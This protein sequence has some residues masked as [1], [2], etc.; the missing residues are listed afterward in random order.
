MG[1][2]DKQVHELAETIEASDCDLVVSATPIDLSRLIKPRK[3]LLQVGY[4]LAEVG[5]PNLEDVLRKF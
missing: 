2:G 5:S 1:Y 4:E 3:P